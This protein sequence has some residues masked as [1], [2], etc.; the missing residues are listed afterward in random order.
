VWNHSVVN[1]SDFD[2]ISGV[3]HGLVIRLSDR[4]TEKDLLLIT[5]FVDVGELRLALE[6]IADVLSEHERPLTTDERSDMLTL[7]ER[8]NMGTRV[9]HVL[10][11]CPDRAVDDAK[12]RAQETYNAAAEFFD[13]PALGF[14]DRFGRATVDRLE[15]KPG[16]VVLDACAGAGASALPAAERVGPT[17][18]VVAVDLADNLLELTRAKADRLGLRHLQ[19][20]HS[21]I[22]AL[23]YPPAT[24]DA[25]IIVFGLFFLPDMA[26]GIEGLWRLVRPGGQLAVTTWGPRLF[27]PANSAFWQ[28]VDQVRPD[29]SRVYNPWDKLTEPDVVCALFAS[30]GAPHAR[31]ES[32]AGSHELRTPEDFWTIVKGSGYR[33]THDALD[34]REREMVRALTIAALTD[35]EVTSI[36]TNVI[37]GTATKPNPHQP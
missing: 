21:D 31:V 8:M 14:W 30:A 33:A 16:A 27:E 7:A 17:G 19:I 35:H 5:E 26:A 12:R 28:A 34:A 22:E 24:F 25:V 36:E 9:P 37:Y 4:L 3:L 20:R 6:Q 15:L 29:L 10:G 18:K 1:Q 2:E 32:V 11:F 23:D 13:D